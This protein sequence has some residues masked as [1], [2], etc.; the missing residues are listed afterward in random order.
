MKSIHK[1]ETGVV[2]ELE[3]G[4]AEFLRGLARRIRQGKR[5]ARYAT[6]PKVDAELRQLLEADLAARRAARMADFLSALDQA[7]RNRIE[8]TDRQAEDW[9]ALLTDLRLALADEIGIV[10]ESWERSLD[11]SKPV[12][13]EVRLYAYLTSLQAVLIEVGFGISR[14]DFLR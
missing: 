9:L 14:A 6:D 12:P 11:L 10:D 8:L 3:R 2:I 1:T 13:E 5:P 4:E 7:R